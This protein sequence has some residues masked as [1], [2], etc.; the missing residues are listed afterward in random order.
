MSERTYGLVKE[1]GLEKN[2]ANTLMAMQAIQDLN[3][4]KDRL[5]T[6]FQTALMLINLSINISDEDEDVL[7]AATVAHDYPELEALEY[8]SDRVEQIIRLLASNGVM[9]DGDKRYY[10]SVLQQDKLGLLLA[11]AERGNLAEGLYNLSASETMEYVRD[12]RKYYL[13]M[14]LYAKQNYP[15]LQMTFNILM[16]KLRSL[17]DIAEIISN[18][19]NVREMSYTNEIFSLMEE[20][21]RLKGMIAQL[22]E[23]SE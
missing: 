21:A 3:L 18:R 10:C 23:Q 2:Q 12:S 13:P 5:E 6:N 1:Y 20:N 8:T 14:C 7:I 16:E 9:R 4:D 19:Y 11:L 17:I 22:V 15:E